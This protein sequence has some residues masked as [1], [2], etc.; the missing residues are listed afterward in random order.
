MIQTFSFVAK[1][2]NNLFLLYFTGFRFNDGLV[3]KI[4]EKDELD[5]DF[6]VSGP[7]QRTRSKTGALPEPPKNARRYRPERK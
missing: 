4:E 5:K 3:L 6:E 2:S 7:S 1:E